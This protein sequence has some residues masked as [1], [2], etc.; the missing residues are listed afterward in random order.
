[1]STTQP[2]PAAPINLAAQIGTR[3]H[4]LMWGQRVTNTQLA[5]MLN[6][7]PTAVG[8]K[9]RADQ[10]FSVEQLAAIAGYLNTT[11]AFLVGESNV[12]TKQRGPVGDQVTSVYKAT[13]SEYTRTMHAKPRPPKRDDNTGPKGRAR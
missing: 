3:V 5:K 1:M 4:T 10:N 13:V 12:P 7:D 2:A 9:L 6:I 8:K 11:I